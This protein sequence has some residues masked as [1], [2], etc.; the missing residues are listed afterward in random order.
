MSAKKVTLQLKAGGTV[1]EY[2]AKAGNVTASLREELQCFVPLCVL[3]VTVEAGSVILTVVATDMDTLGG[4][5]QVESAAVAFAR[6]ITNEP[7]VPDVPDVTD[8]ANVTNATAVLSEVPTLV[9]DSSSLGRWQ[10]RSL[11]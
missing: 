2:E 7:D 8:L 9:V 3:A 1:E 11:G 10:H 4:A 6:S 5:S